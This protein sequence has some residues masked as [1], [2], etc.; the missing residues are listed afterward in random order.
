VQAATEDG[1][2]ARR[3]YQSY[4]KLLEELEAEAGRPA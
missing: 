2:I 1:R 4:L 3:R